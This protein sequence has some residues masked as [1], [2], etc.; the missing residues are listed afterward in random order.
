MVTIISIEGRQ[1]IVNT[2]EFIRR[3]FW[4]LILCRSPRVCAPVPLPSGPCSLIP[5][6]LPSPRVWARANESRVLRHLRWRRRCRPN[7]TS[8]LRW[9]L[10]VCR[11]YL[12][13][14]GLKSL[15]YD[16]M[17]FKNSTAQSHAKKGS[18]RPRDSHFD[19]GCRVNPSNLRKYFLRGS[20]CFIMKMKDQ[21]V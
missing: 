21:Y 9:F 12:R 8:L 7:H 11:V 18:S 4:Y 13:Q 17:N 15:I 6:R 20:V 14:F 2:Y 16:P 1:L 19:F 3:A 5:P 10:F